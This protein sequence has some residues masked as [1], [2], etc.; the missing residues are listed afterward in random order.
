MKKIILITTVILFSV[1]ISGCN[2]YILSNDKNENYKQLDVDTATAIALDYMKEKYGKD[3]DV[4]KSEKEAI[5]GY[6][7]AAIQ[8]C[9]I[10]VTLSEKTNSSEKS[11]IV[12]LR[13][14][15]ISNNYTIDWDNY[16]VP[17]VTEWVDNRI[18]DLLS[19]NMTLPEYFTICANITECDAQGEGFTQNFRGINKD[20]SLQDFFH[21]YKLNLYYSIVIPEKTYEIISSNEINRL[22]HDCFDD[23]CVTIRV[24]AFKDNYYTAYK[25][26][27]E[28]NK[29]IPNGYY[30]NRLY[31]EEFLY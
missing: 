12:R 31:Y 23:D 11:C 24:E 30:P 7:P 17:I 25:E 26:S 13:L 6:V 28:C 4:I 15:E 27:K 3:F 10:N 29:P 8:D 22:F 16:L 2:N 19:E 14:D 18:N 9:Y 5:Y 20:C 1:M 21:S